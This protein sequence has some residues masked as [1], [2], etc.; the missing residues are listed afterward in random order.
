MGQLFRR[1]NIDELPQLW[2]VL[3]G[4]MSLVG[5]RPHPIGMRAA[6]LR[7]EDLVLVYPFRVMVKPGITG[8]AQVRG[9]RGPTTDRKSARMRVVCDLTYIANFSVLFDIRIILVTVLRELRGGTG[10]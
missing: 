10:G 2:N 7:Y 5:P 1:T 4:D 6:S 3:T 9:F 8:L